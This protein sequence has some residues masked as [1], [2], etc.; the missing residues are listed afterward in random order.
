MIDFKPIQYTPKMDVKQIDFTVSKTKGIVSTY[1]RLYNDSMKVISFSHTKKGKQKAKVENT[2]SN[3]KYLANS[4]V[5]ENAKLDYTLDY[6]RTESNKSASQTKTMSNGK[7]KYKT[8]WDYTDRDC[9]EETRRYKSGDK[10]NAK[11]TYEYHSPCDLSKVKL[12][13]GKGKLKKTWTYD[14]KQE[15]EELVQ[16]KNVDQVCRW[17]ESDGE[18]LL[19]V[20]QTFDEK[21][22]LR[23]HVSKYTLKDTL[24]VESKT[25]NQDGII[26]W[27]ATYDK[28]YK[29]PL[30]SKRFSEKGKLRWSTKNEYQ[31]DLLLT[32][33]SFKKW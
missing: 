7:V 31:G 25:F 24:I 20:Y 32:A 29:K 8:E 1:Q 19:K 3:G 15:G 14:C 23:K 10:L 27:H 5:F 13:N 12:F 18:Y 22:K 11:T 16:K 6:L 21:G 9:L 30:E 28:S 17:E 4:K 2:Y 33:Q 26:T